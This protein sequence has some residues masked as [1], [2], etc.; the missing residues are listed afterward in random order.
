MTS[1]VGAEQVWKKLAGRKSHEADAESA[2]LSPGGALGGYDGALGLREGLDGF[3]IEGLA[4]RSKASDAPVSR[5]EFDTELTLEIG[6]GFADGGL[7]NV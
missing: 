5:E 3:F 4:F 2:C 6:Y 1:L 7:G